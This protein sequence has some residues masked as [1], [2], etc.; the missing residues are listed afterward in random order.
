M[1]LLLPREGL[2]AKA[3]TPSMLIA[4]KEGRA[5]VNAA[6]VGKIGRARARM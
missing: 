6:R 2:I 1:R 4:A 3:V 5:R